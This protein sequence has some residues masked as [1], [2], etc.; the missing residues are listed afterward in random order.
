MS[1]HCLFFGWYTKPLGDLRRKVVQ[2]CPWGSLVRWYVLR[3]LISSDSVENQ[4]NFIELYISDKCNWHVNNM[5]EQIVIGQ[6]VRTWKYRYVLL[7]YLFTS[8]AVEIFPHCVPKHM[9]ENTIFWD[10]WE[11]KHT[12]W[13][14]SNFTAIMLSFPMLL[15][16]PIV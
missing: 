9:N 5:T 14:I 10:S 15:Y 2:C 1:R 6:V 4:Y 12:F 16:H 7:W 11:H 3:I 13:S 8:D